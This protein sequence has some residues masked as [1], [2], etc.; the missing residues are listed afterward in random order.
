MLGL[1]DNLY[2]RAV[3]RHLGECELDTPWP[4]LYKDLPVRPVKV[5]TTLRTQRKNAS[6]PESKY[7][8]PKVRNATPLGYNANGTILSSL[9]ASAQVPMP[10]QI[11]MTGPPTGATPSNTIIIRP[12]TVRQEWRADARNPKP[13]YLARIADALRHDFTV[14]SVADLQSGH[15]W[16][17]GD[18]P[19]AHE[20]YHCG[21]L[22]VEQLMGMVNGA[23]GTVGG[24]GWLTPASIA[25]KTPHLCVF[26]GW[27]QA[28]GP[29]RIF[30]PRLDVSNIVQAM[31]DSY[32]MCNDK[33][34]A[35]A[36]T[37][38]KL[39]DYIE[40]FYNIA[41]ARSTNLVA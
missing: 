23:A 8:T 25:Y 36:K 29:Q 35:C 19:F 24:V 13:E 33:L 39:D 41:K 22:D 37:I 40:R 14:V 20:T 9:F 28:N 31:P 1:G 7:F 10:A 2:Q 27:G 5:Q 6:R 11:D 16:L 30:D 18:A 21:E 15:E 17:A 12:A 3:L 32:C 4:Q 26:G 34:H 38:Q